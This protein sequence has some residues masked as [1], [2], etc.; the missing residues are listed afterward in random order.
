MHSILVTGVCGSGKSTLA[1]DASR[2]LGIAVH[3]YADLMLKA[4]PAINGKDAIE[5]LSPSQ[6]ARVYE[7]VRELLDDWFGPA[8]NSDA[9]MLL[10][11]HLSIM[12]DGTII[13]FPADAYRR[14]NALGLAVIDADPHAVLARRRSDPARHRHTGTADEIAAQQQVNSE[15]ARIITRYLG[16][17]QLHVDNSGDGTQ[18][19]AGY[20][21]GWALGLQQA[22]RLAA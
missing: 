7:A 8:S 2:E 17:P 21:A 10:E 1:L 11:N 16:I 3:D 13:T 15:Q 18:H 14:Y 20:L 6:R 19:A 12:Q 5:L 4:S 22:L 9:V